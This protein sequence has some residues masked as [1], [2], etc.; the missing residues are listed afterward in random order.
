MK[1]LT[2]FWRRRR[3]Q[4][5]AVGAVRD[6]DETVAD[7]EGL[8][9][10][11]RG[12][13]DDVERARCEVAGGGDRGL[14]PIRADGDSQRPIVDFNLRAGRHD[15]L[16]VRKQDAAVRLDANKRDRDEACDTDRQERGDQHRSGHATEVISHDGRL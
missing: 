16:A 9:H 3:V 12:Q 5:L 6:A 11:L 15:C 14:G 2:S 7:G 8:R 4:R 1:T 10:G 13:I